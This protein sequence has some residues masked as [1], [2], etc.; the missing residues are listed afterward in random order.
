M[1]FIDQPVE[2]ENF[3]LPDRT[4]SHLGVHLC[5]GQFSS[6]LRVVFLVR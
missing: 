1:A 5:A 3:T 2:Q 6:H 4:E